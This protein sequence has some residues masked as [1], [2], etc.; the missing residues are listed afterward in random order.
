MKNAIRLWWYAITVRPA[1]MYDGERW[2]RLS[3]AIRHRDGFKCQHRRFGIGP[4]CGVSRGLQVHHRWPWAG[5]Q[6][7]FGRVGFRIANLP[8]M[9]TTLC[10]SHHET[11]HGRDLDHNGRI[12]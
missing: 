9:L 12:G 4:K 10:Q 11:A 8:P 7:R 1:D 6:R 2:R 3:L 5:A